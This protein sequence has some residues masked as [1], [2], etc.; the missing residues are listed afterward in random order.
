MINV[1]YAT[2]SGFRATGPKNLLPTQPMNGVLYELGPASHVIV[3]RGSS[4]SFSMHRTREDAHRLSARES[5]RP[6]TS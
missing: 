6:S 1:R 5:S 3:P 2:D 4:T